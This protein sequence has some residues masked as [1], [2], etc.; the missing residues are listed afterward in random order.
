MHRA[1]EHIIDACEGL[2]EAHARGIIHQD[3]KPANLVVTGDDGRPCVK[4]SIPGIA[5]MRTNDPKRREGREVERAVPATPAYLSPEQLRGSP[6]VDHRTDVWALGCVLYEILSGERAFRSTRFT[7]LVT[8]ILES[9][10]DRLP[11]DLELPSP[12]ALV[13]ERCLEKDLRKRF[14]STGALALAL[15]RSLDAERMS[16]ARAVAHEGRRPRSRPRDAGVAAAADRGL[17]ERRR[18]SQS[19]PP[20]RSSPSTRGRIAASTTPRWPAS[21]STD[22]TER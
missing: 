15:C 12:V 8:K 6:P 16:V 1:V 11:A 13:I 3:V 7:E 4:P 5:T 9:E 2:A 20:R 22:A 10:P 17:R 19:F 14:A 21:S 18:R